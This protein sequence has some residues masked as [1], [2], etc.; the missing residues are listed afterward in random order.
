MRLRRQFPNIYMF[1]FA[2]VYYPYLSDL[3]HHILLILQTIPPGVCSL[4]H[5]HIMDKLIAS[6][7][8]FLNRTYNIRCQEKNHIPPSASLRLA[9]VYDTVRLN[10]FNTQISERMKEFSPFFLSPL[11]RFLYV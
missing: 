6:L 4:V 3:I 7:L 9:A 5:V 8:A 1:V 11:D 2:S 10:R